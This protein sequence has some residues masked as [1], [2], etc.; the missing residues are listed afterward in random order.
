MHLTD[1]LD[2]TGR[3]TPTGPVLFSHSEKLEEG[4]GSRRVEALVLI[5]QLHIMTAKLLRPFLLCLSDSYVA[6]R[7]Q[8]CHTAGELMM[9]DSMVRIMESLLCWDVLLF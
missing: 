7:K 6:V 9:T 5:G 1:T 2:L 4:P 8:G 3:F